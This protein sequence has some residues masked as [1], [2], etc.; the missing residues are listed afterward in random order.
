MRRRIERITASP[1]FARIRAA[2]T[3]GSE[4]PVHSLGEGGRLVERRIDR[5]LRDESGYIVL[6]YK[7]GRPRPERLEEDRQQVFRYCEAISAITGE[8]CGGYLWYI[9]ADRDEL[10]DVP[11]TLANTLG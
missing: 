10:V 2:E 3:V 11:G 4:V 6:D 7:S 5:L 1:A 8:S 9:D